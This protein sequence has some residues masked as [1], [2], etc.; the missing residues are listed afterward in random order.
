MPVP[1][2]SA[3]WALMNESNDGE[4]VAC[5]YI[6]WMDVAAYTDWAALRPF[7]ELE[8]E[9]ACRGGQTAVNDEYAWGNTTLEPLT[10]SLLNKGTKS[11][12]PNQG[13]ANVGGSQPQGPYRCGSYAGATSTRTN[14]GAG[15][16][17]ALDLSGNLYERTVTVGNTTGRGFTGTPGDGSLTSTGDATNS[18]WPGFVTSA[19]T[20]A[21]GSGFRGGD[22]L[23]Y[24]RYA[25]VS[26]RNDAA[27]TITSRYY[28]LGGRCARASP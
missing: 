12:A 14:S 19:V 10:T 9:K 28:S 4:W 22:W 5:N 2:G 7:T 15:Y 27:I 17:G 3:N 21:T 8:F 20:T 25:R 24:T 1:G 11:E 6:S 13:N 23:Y 26:D 16:Y 18:D